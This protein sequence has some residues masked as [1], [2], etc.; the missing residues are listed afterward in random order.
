MYITLLT[1][2]RFHFLTRQRHTKH[3]LSSTPVP[4]L[5]LLSAV[6]SKNISLFVL[7]NNTHAHNCNL[8]AYNIIGTTR[9]D[10]ASDERFDGM[11]LSL[12]QNL[13]GGIEQLLDVFFSFL[14]RKTDFFTGALEGEARK[15]SWQDSGVCVCARTLMT[16][17]PRKGFIGVCVCA[18]VCIKCS[19]FLENSI[20]KCPYHNVWG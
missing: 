10:M 13:D 8:S 6:A 20:G 16:P 17:S 7:S 18:R 12:A 14:G 3:F 11:L 1:A 15:V 9:A 2:H 19:Q 5:I 4:L